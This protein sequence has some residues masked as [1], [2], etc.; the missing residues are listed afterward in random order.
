MY[1]CV[2]LLSMGSGTVP[3]ALVGFSSGRLRVF[4]L[5]TGES[6]LQQDLTVFLAAAV[7]ADGASPSPS[8]DTHV[9]WTEGWPVFFCYQLSSCVVLWCAWCVSTISSSEL[10]LVH[11]PLPLCPLIF[12]FSG[13]LG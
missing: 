12:D 2:S 3:V 4:D 6:V 5:L 7:S 13:E 8:L 1:V 10:H 9:C 11:R